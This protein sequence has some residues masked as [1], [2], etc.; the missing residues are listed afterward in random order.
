MFGNISKILELKKQAEEMKKKLD[1]VE[2]FHQE[3]GISV[4]CN[5]HGKIT[6]LE[7]EDSLLNEK[8]KLIN[9]LKSAINEASSKAQK[10]AV[11]NLGDLSNLFGT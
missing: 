8:S 5:G 9:S 10:Q 2:V 7:I 4:T 6:N 1:T 3:N 11:G